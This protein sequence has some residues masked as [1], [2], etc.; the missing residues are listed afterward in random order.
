MS[1]CKLSAALLC[2]AALLTTSAL[3]DR[4]TPSERVETRKGRVL[5]TLVPALNEAD[6]FA[7]ACR[8]AD[9]PIGCQVIFENHRQYT[10]VPEK[11]LP[12]ACRTNQQ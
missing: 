8:Y 2:A 1:R 12:V 10:D 5:L 7:W 6:G 11:F 3:A 9:P 4:V